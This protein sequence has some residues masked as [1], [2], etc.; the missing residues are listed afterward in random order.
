MTTPARRT[1]RMASLVAPLAFARAVLAGCGG[2]SSGRSITLYNG[3]HVQTTDALVAAFEKPTGIRV[4]VRSDDED[5]LADEIVTEGSQLARRRDLHREL[6]RARVPAG[7]GPARAGRPVDA[8]AHPEQVQLAAGRLG[9][10]VGAGQRAD[11]QP[12]PDQRQR[13]P[14]LGH[15]AGRPEVQGQA[16]LRRRRDRLPAD[17]DLRR[18]HLRPGG[19]AAAGSKGSRPTPAATST[20]TTRRSPTRST[21]AR[22][23]S[24]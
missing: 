15:A 13:A 6:A 20:P 18:A 19:G 11:L 23:P 1:P 5:I 22:S 8:R 3:Q 10:G 21:A 2:S 7:Q 12:E 9:R 4:N 16:R 24:G 17:R 14:D